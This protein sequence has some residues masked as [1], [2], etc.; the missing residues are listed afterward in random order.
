MST[1]APEP[2]AN[3]GQPIPRYDAVPKVTGEA[4]YAADV[5]LA[6]PA[7]A[8]LVTSTIARGR[9]DGF[10]L[11]EAKSVRGVIDVFTYENSE[12]LKDAKLFSNGGYASTTIQPLKS[13]D[14]GHE[15]EIVAVVVADSF[16]AA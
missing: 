5:P 15:G 12:R 14:I 16:E 9:I 13:P 1:A 11:A 3:M 6:K 7:F 10:D 2:K 4:A 8:Y